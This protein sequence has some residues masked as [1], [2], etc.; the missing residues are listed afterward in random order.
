MM[1]K[2]QGQLQIRS[3]KDRRVAWNAAVVMIFIATIGWMR[4]QQALRHW[5]Y[6]INLGVWPPPVYQAVSGGLIG[7][8]FSLG[9]IFH[10]LKRPFTISYL[11]VINALLFVWLWIDRIFIAIRDYFL[12][13]LAGTISISVCLLCV[14]ILL[15]RKITYPTMKVEDEPEN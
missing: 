3:K 13:R 15:Y 6:L 9:L 4:F 11:R 2:T 10:I 14:D 1:E 8:S 12:L 5:Y 7:I